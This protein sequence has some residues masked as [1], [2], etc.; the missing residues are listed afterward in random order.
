MRRICVKTLIILAFTSVAV[1]RSAAE[2]SSN[3]IDSVSSLD[4]GVYFT[5]GA[6]PYFSSASQSRTGNYDV[7]LGIGYG[8]LSRFAFGLKVYTGT[9]NIDGESTKPASGKFSLGGVGIEF[10][11]RFLTDGFLRPFTALG[12]DH[13]TILNVDGAGYNGGGLHLEVGTELY[14]TDYLSIG[15]GAVYKSIRF[16]DL[17]LLSSFKDFSDPFTDSM[18]RLSVGI[19]FYSD[20][21]P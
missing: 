14:L 2:M 1:S 19:S 4:H 16:N 15:L 9:D 18:M 3:I 13:F 5:F 21:L 17:I 7:Y 8:F 6:G 10:K 11:F 12:Y 20:S